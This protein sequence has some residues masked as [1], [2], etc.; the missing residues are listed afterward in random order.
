[1]S[2]PIQPAATQESKTASPQ[3]ATIAQIKAACPGSA[4]KADWLLAQVERGATLEQ[5]KD[6]WMLDQRAA[7]ENR[8]RQLEEA[9]AAQVKAGVDHIGESALAGG[10]ESSATTPTATSGG[11]ALAEFRELIASEMKVGG[12]DRSTAAGRV[13]RRNP[14][15]HQRV[16]LET[17]PPKAHE[18][19]RE[20][21]AGVA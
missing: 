10:A 7:L 15:L 9:R 12:C 1:M 21:F 8:D 14:D 3:A 19:V 6:A 16:L 5:A 18:R 4:D 17:T 11:G 13:V 2:E 20:R